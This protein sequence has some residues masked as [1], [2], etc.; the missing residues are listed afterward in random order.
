MSPRSSDVASY[1]A[2]GAWGVWCVDHL[3]HALLHTC[4]VLQ[5]QL[6]PNTQLSL[7]SVGSMLPPSAACCVAVA[8]RHRVP[9]T[10]FCKDGGSLHVYPPPCWG[11]D[12]SEQIFGPFLDCSR[13]SGR[14]WCP[15]QCHPSVYAFVRH[16]SACGLSLSCR[17]V[18]SRFRQDKKARLFCVARPHLAIRKLLGMRGCVCVG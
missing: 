4:P 17:L 10:P 6:Q 14:E 13:Q 12:W 1:T 2:L 5:Q 8:T 3:S 18:G 7:C 11:W 16:A 15:L 9:L